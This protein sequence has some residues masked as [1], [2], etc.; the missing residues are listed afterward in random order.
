MTIPCPLPQRYTTSDPGIGG[1]LKD[2][3]EDFVVEEIPL[4]D[5]CDSG[6]H[7]Y[8]WIEKTNVSHAELMSRLRRHFDVHERA[9]GYAGMKDKRAI[10]RQAVTVHCLKDPASLDLDHERIKILWS[11]R[12][13]NK[14]RRGHLRGNRF[15]IRVR[16]V[17]PLRAPAVHRTMQTLTR[18]GVPGYYGNQRFGYRQNS[19]LLGAFVL[20]E[21]WEDAVDE[22]LGSRGS[23]FPDYQQERRELYDAGRYEETVAHWSTAD[24]SEL[25]A[26]KALA[27]GAK[28]RDA[29]LRLG[30]TTLRFFTSAFSSAAF[31]RVL[32]R[33]INDGQLDQLH[34]GDL[35]WKHDSRAV[36]AVTAE[37]ARSEEIPARLSRMEISPSGP[38][39]GEGMTR[40]GGAIG[41][42]EEEA[43]A[44]TGVPQQALVSSRFGPEGA[45]R[46]LR[47]PI[48]NISVSGG[49][50]EHGPSIDVAFDL[51][52]GMYA[53]VV[54]REIMKA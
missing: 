50:D 54:L 5:A 45:R 19:H 25:I 40:A 51:P 14:L 11:T 1:T 22:L 38:L 36:F 23:S 41:D 6:E 39:W 44:A 30:G 8:L 46:P 42:I 4:Y 32:D 12:H 37:E 10:T 52:R 43:L 13:R 17:D 35:A 27:R 24:R 18:T 33:R 26:I 47:T 34:D 31:N 49:M 3:P 9:I 2:R 16:D 15:A 20:A 48:E 29:L 21:R 28:P 7:L 53:T